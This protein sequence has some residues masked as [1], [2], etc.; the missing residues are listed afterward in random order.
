MIPGE[1]EIGV[2]HTGGINHSDIATWPNLPTGQMQ[3]IPICFVRFP[4][5]HPVS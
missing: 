5:L 2:D 1:K 4:N 3:I